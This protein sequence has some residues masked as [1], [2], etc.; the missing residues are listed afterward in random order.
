MEVDTVEG[1]VVCVNSEEVLQALS[2]INTGKA[3]GPSE[4]SLEL[5][6]ANGGIGIHVIS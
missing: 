4:A 5:I 2:E 3:S 6:A 1:P